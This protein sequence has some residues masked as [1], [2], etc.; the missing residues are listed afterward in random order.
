[1]HLYTEQEE[2]QIYKRDLTQV[3]QVGTQKYMIHQ[4]KRFI[5][6]QIVGKIEWEGMTTLD[7]T[8]SPVYLQIFNQITNLWETIATNNDSC[9]ND[10]FE[11]EGDIDNLTNYKDADNIVSSRVYQLAISTTEWKLS[12]DYFTILIPILYGDQ[13]TIQGNTSTGVYAD[14]PTV[15]QKVYV[16]QENCYEREYPPVGDD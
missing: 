15:N 5:S 2:E 13:Y 14:K 1:M 7:P 10:N 8:L 12:T 6:P 11:L 4:F 9:T 3:S 16:A